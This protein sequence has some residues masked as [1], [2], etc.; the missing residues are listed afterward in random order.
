[1]AEQNVANVTTRVRFSSPAPD[2]ENT[3]RSSGTRSLRD[4]VCYGRVFL[5]TLPI[6][7]NSMTGCCVIYVCNT[8]I[9]Q[10]VQIPNNQNV[11]NLRNQ[12]H[13]F[14][15]VMIGDNPIVTKNAHVVVNSKMMSNINF[16]NS[17]GNFK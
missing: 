14:P 4:T 15:P 17:K 2:N 12:N 6:W 5:A 7:V 16:I 10:T 11:P 8:I 9:N 13:T 3:A 1:M